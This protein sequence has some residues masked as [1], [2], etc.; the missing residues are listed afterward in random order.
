MKYYTLMK[1]LSID[2]FAASLFCFIAG[3]AWAVP[4][5]EFRYY[6]IDVGGGQWKYDYTL[7][8]RSD[9]TLDAGF[10][11]FDVILKFNPSV[12]FSV[13]TLPQGWNEISGAGFIEAF[14]E[15]PGT[16]FPGTDI[17][18]GEFS[19][20]FTFEFNAR[21]QDLPFEA[22][23]T[24]PNLPDEPLVFRSTTAQIPEPSTLLLLGVGL[25]GGIVIIR[26]RK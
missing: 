13:V 16:V 22:T 7:F 1:R 2:L 20:W 4:A 6:E 15:N 17:G 23:F 8:N 10:N 24:N 26:R 9:P 21:L 18:P 19:R 5:T 25:G 12:S 14:S 11:I 3:M